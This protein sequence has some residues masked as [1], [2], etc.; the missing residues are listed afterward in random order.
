M[1]NNTNAKGNVM[2]ANTWEWRDAMKNPTDGRGHGRKDSFNESTLREIPQ[3]V[4]LHNQGKMSREISR[5]VGI[6]DITVKKVLANEKFRTPECL[7]KL[8]QRYGVNVAGSSNYTMHPHTHTHSPRPWPVGVGANPQFIGDSNGNIESVKIAEE[9]PQM[10]ANDTVTTK[11][12]ESVSPQVSTTTA[13][14]AKS[15][16]H[17][18]CIT[19]DEAIDRVRK[20]HYPNSPWDNEQYLF[21][22]EMILRAAFPSDQVP[23]LH[24]SFKILMSSAIAMKNAAIAEQ[25]KAAKAEA[26]AAAWRADLLEITKTLMLS[27]A[28][29]KTDQPPSTTP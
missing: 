4:A 22:Q 18:K 13:T 28:P 6:S 12:A 26:D 7:D 15:I 8:K 20:L 24:C 14:P 19:V 11:I 27:V 3:I 5:I 1:R 23:I 17:I 21:D 2:N 16:K 29:P 10:P 9:S 25:I